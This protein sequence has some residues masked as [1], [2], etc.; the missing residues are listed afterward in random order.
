MSY[1]RLPTED[2]T[3]HAIEL[4]DRAIK[5]RRIVRVRFFKEKKDRRDRRQWF[6]DSLD[7]VFGRRVVLEAAPVVRTVEPLEWTTNAAGEPYMVG[8]CH[9]AP[10]TERPALRTIRIDRIPVTRDGL[11]MEVTDRAFKVEGTMLDPRWE[12]VI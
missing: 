10:N 9:D 4:I 12:G 3:F 6:N 8:I 11:R 5:E 1:G 7:A 2:E